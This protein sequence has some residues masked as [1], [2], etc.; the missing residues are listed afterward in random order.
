MAGF[1]NIK[2]TGD[3]ELQKNL[4]KLT[5]ALQ[6]KIT[7]KALRAAAKPVLAAAKAA[8]PTVTGKRTQIIKRKLKIKALKR[9]R[10]S[11]GVQIVTPTVEELG[12]NES[13]S[14]NYN[15][16]VAIELGTSDTPANPFLRNSLETHR[17]SSTAIAASEIKKGIAT[18]LASVK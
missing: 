7:R 5:F 8:V 13:E 14:S 10:R 18:T 17:A 1:V 3:K 2:L 9:S 16:I 4:K 15:Y 6:K 12:L 11:I